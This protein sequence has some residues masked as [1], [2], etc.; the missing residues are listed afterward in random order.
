MTDAMTETQILVVD[1][2]PKI[3]DLISDIADEFGI[4]VET[5]SNFEAFENTFTGDRFKAIVLDLIMPDKDGIEYLRLLSERQC[6]SRVAL[7]SGYDK[8]VLQTARR[9]GES[10]DLFMDC[11]FEKP[12]DETVL[13]AFLES[14]GGESD[15]L[16]PRDLESAIVSG[17]LFLEYQPK[18]VV[19]ED[20]TSTSPVLRL[21]LGSS[22]WSVSSFEALVRWRHPKLGK[23]GADRFIPMAEETGLI[24]PLT[25]EVNRL[26]VHQV[27]YW[28]EAGHKVKVALN[29]PAAALVD[30]SAPDRFA[31]RVSAAGL[32]T[33]QFIIEI[34]ETA[35][36]TDP[37]KAMDVLS[38]IRLKGFDLSMD[39]FGKGYSSLIQLHR[40]PFSELKI[41]Q[42]IISE[43]GKSEEAETI[44]LTIIELS[45]KLGL[46]VCAEGVE[47]RSAFEFL[48]SVGCDTA[49]GYFVSAPLRIDRI[50]LKS[51]A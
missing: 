42:S 29:W 31:D 9:F 43:F 21:T 2:D 27:R 8:R 33:Q 17:D 15:E 46:K 3:C 25:E 14:L 37:P 30:I 12:F 24:L 38:R 49:Q 11:V 44:L 34:T 40:M 4:G 26:A 20:A 51:E 19:K 10:Q 35:A 47:E 16:T 6:R 18:V 39:D 7:M 45:H 22:E 13:K 41:D 48:Q 28:A 36:M 23:V 1:D 50:Q 32:S 5:A